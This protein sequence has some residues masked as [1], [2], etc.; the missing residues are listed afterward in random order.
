MVQS[1]EIIFKMAEGVNVKLTLPDA[2]V[3]II[4]ITDTL[5]NLDCDICVNRHLPIANTKLL[6]FYASLD[7]RVPSNKGCRP[8]NG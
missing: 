4:K 6:A 8:Q 2:K 7:P 1:L 3:P 5:S